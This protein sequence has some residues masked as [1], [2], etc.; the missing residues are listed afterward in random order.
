MNALAA[1][2]LRGDAVIAITEGLLSRL[3]QQQL[4]AVIA[5][6]AY[7]VLSGDCREATLATSLF[8]MYLSLLE[9]MQSFAGDE[10]RA[11]LAPSF[12]PLWVLLKMSMLLSLLI[13]REREYRADAASVRMTRN[14]VAMAEALYFLAHNWR[15]SGI[16]SSGIEMLCIVN[17]VVSLPDE[18]DGWWADLISTHPPIMKRI[19]ILLDMARLSSEALSRRMLKEERPDSAGESG[20][21]G[22]DGHTA[23][24]VVFGVASP[25]G[26]PACRQPLQAVEYEGTEVHNCSL[27]HGTLVENDK[28]PRLIA[29]REKRCSLRVMSLAA[30]SAGDN[31]RAL[32]VRRRDITGRR[33]MAGHT[34]PK[35]R[36]IMFRTFYSGAYLI[37]IDRCNVCGISWFDPDELEMLQC[38][39]ENRITGTMDSPSQAEGS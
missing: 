29:R 27:C 21:Q 17:P 6:E 1:D 39:I 14:P 16:I 13:S 33:S 2:D 4:Q 32:S 38:L 26:C 25:Y 12:L 9:G 24:S 30:A 35:C 22:D 28:L 36:N 11:G 3:S 37:E 10:R 7:H 31:Q 34:C 5:H 18:S 23:A 15:G 8:G 19:S 20:G